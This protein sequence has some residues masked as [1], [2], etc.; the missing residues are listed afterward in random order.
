VEL[1]T[2]GDVSADANNNICLFFEAGLAELDLSSSP[3]WPGERILTDLIAQAAGLF[4]WVETIM[5]LLGKGT[6]NEQLDLILRG[7]FGDGDDLRAVKQPDSLHVVSRC[8]LERQP[9]TSLTDVYFRQL[10][11][12]RQHSITMICLSSCRRIRNR[13]SLSL[14]SC[15]LLSRLRTSV[16]RHLSLVEFLCDPKRCPEEFFID[17]PKRSR[18]H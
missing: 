14:T 1:P 16:F 4:I 18:K 15:H 5:R 13:S 6:P 3:Q 7:H 12:L 17:R 8:R 11:S 2:G 10:L 9:D